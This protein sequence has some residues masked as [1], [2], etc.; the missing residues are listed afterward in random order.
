M[1]GLTPSNLLSLRSG[2][3]KERDGRAGG[4]I[5]FDVCFNPNT[6]DVGPADIQVTLICKS[7]QCFTDSLHHMYCQLQTRTQEILVVSRKL[8]IRNELR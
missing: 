1:L 7:L 5:A 8:A 3:E 6:F 2:E 4:S